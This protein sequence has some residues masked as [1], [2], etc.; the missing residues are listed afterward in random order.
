MVTLKT[1]VTNHTIFKDSL[2]G[3]LAFECSNPWR[4]NQEGNQMSDATEG[5]PGDDRLARIGFYIWDPIRDTRKG[6]QNL[7]KLK[8]T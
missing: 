4:G 1:S 3:V 6:F 8:E 7:G 2:G 5:V